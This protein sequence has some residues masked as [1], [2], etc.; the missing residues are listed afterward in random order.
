MR[1]F[2]A[3]ESKIHALAT[4]QH[5]LVARRQLLHVGLGED[6]IDHR[7]A[8]GR[9]MKVERGVYAL[10][11]KELRREGRALAVVLGAGGRAV[12]SHRSAA[13]LWG[14]GHGAERSSRS[15]CQAGA[16]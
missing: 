15:R 10:G 7:L 9:L 6:A 14:T 8:T 5:G 4:R 1:G 12:L 2:H 3:I 16:A 11:H 13:A